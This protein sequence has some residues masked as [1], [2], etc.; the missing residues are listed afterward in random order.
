MTATVVTVTVTVTARWV[1]PGPNGPGRPGHVTTE[2]FDAHDTRARLEGHSGCGGTGRLAADE[3]N[4]N[5]LRPSRWQP[6]RP[7]W[8][9]GAEFNRDGVAGRAVLLAPTGKFG[10]VRLGLSEAATQAGNAQ[11]RSVKFKF[12]LT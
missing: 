12:Q 5:V 4:L 11:V 8:P 7:Q 9:G 6:P 2:S 10:L 1:A 3:D